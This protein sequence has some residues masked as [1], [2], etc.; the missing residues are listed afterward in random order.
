MAQL[1]TQTRYQ[2]QV[3]ADRRAAAIQRRVEREM[4]GFCD[5]DQVNRLYTVTDWSLAQP[6]LTPPPL[7]PII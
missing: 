3:K 2:N 1:N 6:P 5:V 7:Y 4:V